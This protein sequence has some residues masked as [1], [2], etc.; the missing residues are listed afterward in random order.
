AM[1]GAQAIGV[2]SEI[3]PA[4]TTPHQ[5]I[6]APVVI[7]TFPR[8]FAARSG[9]S[10]PRERRRSAGMRFPDFCGTYERLRGPRTIV[11]NGRKFTH[12]ALNRPA[13]FC[14][15]QVGRSLGEGCRVSSP[16]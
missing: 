4:Y 2:A 1:A 8:L 16:R 6:A 12:A 9:N 5:A 14:D 13:A 11:Q 15:P 7:S 3:D 10:G